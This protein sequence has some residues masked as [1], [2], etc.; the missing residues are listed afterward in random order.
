MDS[1]CQGEAEVI[2]GIGCKAVILA[3]VYNQTWPLIV[4]YW[5]SPIGFCNVPDGGL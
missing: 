4:A 2:A 1:T 3:E 5:N